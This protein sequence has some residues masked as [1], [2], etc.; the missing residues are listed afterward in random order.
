[1][2]DEPFWN[3]GDAAE[4][5]ADPTAPPGKAACPACGTV[6]V[7]AFTHQRP[8]DFAVCAHCQATLIIM[9]NGL[10]R[11]LTYDEAEQADADPLIQFMKLA[12]RDEPLPGPGE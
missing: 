12:F 8:G 4:M 3:P 6:F 9:D 11:L 5:P 7:S 2:T 1:M 10:P